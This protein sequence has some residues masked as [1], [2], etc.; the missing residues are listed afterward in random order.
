MSGALLA[1][2]EHGLNSSL[3]ALC[4]EPRTSGGYRSSG[5]LGFLGF[6]V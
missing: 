5:G 1:V 6:E 4:R 3:V 2:T